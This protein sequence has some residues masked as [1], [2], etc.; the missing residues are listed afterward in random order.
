MYK[1]IDNQRMTIHE[2]SE[3]YPDSMI[4]IRL[5]SVGSETGTVI[6]IGD[7]DSDVIE[8]L[9]T[10]EDDSKCLVT[11]GRNLRCYLGGVVVGA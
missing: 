4:V 1:I 6:C 8:F 10:L 2:A 5:D 3:F 11:E 9:G 7:E